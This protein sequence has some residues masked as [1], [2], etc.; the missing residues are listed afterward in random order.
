MNER[1]ALLELIDWEESCIDYSN[2]CISKESKDI[3]KATE[4]IKI[5]KKLLEK[6]K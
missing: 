2:R 5:Y 6:L 1:E 4:K 3:K